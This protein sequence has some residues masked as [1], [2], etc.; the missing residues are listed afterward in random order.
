MDS[1]FIV[2]LQ[3][4]PVMNGM[5]VRIYRAD[6]TLEEIPAP[7]IIAEWVDYKNDDEDNL[8]KELGVV[9]EVRPGDQGIEGSRGVV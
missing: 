9:G 7:L 3:S 5:L 4:D 6:G 2:G 1:N 8:T